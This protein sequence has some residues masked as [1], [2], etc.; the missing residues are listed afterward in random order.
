MLFRSGYLCDEHE[1]VE[2]RDMIAIIR[3][4]VKGLISKGASLA[5]VQAA[6]P[7]ADYDTRYGSNTGDWTTAK[8]VEA[9]YR[10]LPG[11]TQKK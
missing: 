9:V 7:T 6:R 11:P 10:S 2:Y 1:V 5:E 8:F 4:R 3:D